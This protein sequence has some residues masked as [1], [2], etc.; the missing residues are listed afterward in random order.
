MQKEVMTVSEVAEYLRVN[1]QTVYRKAK[2]GELPA[3]RIGRAIRF[4][5]SELDAW[6]KESSSM[7]VGAGSR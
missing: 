5:R 6:M 4:R 2:V 1:P 7:L 3:V